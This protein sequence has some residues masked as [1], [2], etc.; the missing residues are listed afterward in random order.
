MVVSMLSHCVGGESRRS[1][2]PSSLSPRPAPHFPASTRFYV[3]LFQLHTPFAL[4]T[5]RF[6]SSTLARP[7]FGASRRQSFLRQIP[8][9]LLAY[10]RFP[11]STLA[12]PHG[13]PAQRSHV[14]SPI[15]SHLFAIFT[16]SRLPGPVSGTGCTSTCT[17]PDRAGE[18]LRLL[19]MAAR[20]S[21]LSRL[22]LYD[23]RRKEA[24]RRQA[25][26][27]LF[28]HIL[29]AFQV[30]QASHS[31][32]PFNFALASLRPKP[33]SRACSRLWQAQAGGAGNVGAD[34]VKARSQCEPRLDLFH[35]LSRI[36]IMILF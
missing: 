16:L 11:T 4:S 13:S 21:T 15:L 22:P 14:P 26:G 8:S 3:P 1:V 20:S 23:L 34:S 30:K 6:A 24:G 36:K 2:H 5:S 27:F 7:W 19:S 12:R 31:T 29:Y 9:P 33:V 25:E 35:C 10:T 28:L 18:S 32:L 17:P